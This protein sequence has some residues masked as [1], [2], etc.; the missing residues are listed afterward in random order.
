MM[1]I[2]GLTIWGDPPELP[3]RQ[4]V[5]NRKKEL[6]RELIKLELDHIDMGVRKVAAQHKIEYLGKFLAD[7]PAP[8]PMQVLKK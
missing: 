4:S 5:E 1:Q 3:L 6:E 7:L 8:T 2:F